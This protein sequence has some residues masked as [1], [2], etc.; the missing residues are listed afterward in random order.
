[1]CLEKVICRYPIYSKVTAM[2]LEKVNR[3]LIN[4]DQTGFLKGRMASENVRRLLHI[5]SVT[6]KTGLPC[7]LLFLDAERHLTAWNGD[8]R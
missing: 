7:G 1:M 6:K 5:I 3:K 4:P 2:R 8:I